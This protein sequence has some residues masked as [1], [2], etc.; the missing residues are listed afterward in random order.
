MKPVL[1]IPRQAV[2][3]AKENVK[4][5]GLKD[6]LIEAYPQ[7]FSGIANKDPPDCGK[8]GTAKIKVKPNPKTN[9]HEGY[10]LQ[11]ERA[12]AMK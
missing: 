1:S 11:E 10:Q 2:E 3:E 9:R 12:E 4:V 5:A 8:F 6:R 7:L